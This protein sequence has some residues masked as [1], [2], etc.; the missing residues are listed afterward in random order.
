MQQWAFEMLG[1]TSLIGHLTS[2]TPCRLFSID[3]LHKT[4]QK[5]SFDVSAL[6][7]ERKMKQKKFKLS[8]L[9]V[10]ELKAMCKWKE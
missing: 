7:D 1:M 8:T 6:V 10:A 3:L 2:P 9:K 5:W 4:C